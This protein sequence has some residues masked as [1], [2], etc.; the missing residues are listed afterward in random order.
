MNIGKEGKPLI[1]ERPDETPAPI[2]QPPM[3]V[4]PIQEP[5]KAPVGV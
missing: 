3:P 4:E 2:E 5:E 1:V